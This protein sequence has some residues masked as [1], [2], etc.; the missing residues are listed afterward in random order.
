[1]VGVANGNPIAERQT[2]YGSE[3]V[4]GRSQLGRG[5]QLRS[6]LDQMREAED[7]QWAELD[8]DQ[9]RDASLFRPIPLK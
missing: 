9:G 8:W 1:M 3:A 6:K 5:G 2:N 4:F 7:F